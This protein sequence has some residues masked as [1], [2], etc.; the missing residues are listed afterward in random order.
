MIGDDEKEQEKDETGIREETREE[1]EE[2]EK[3]TIQKRKEVVTTSETAEENEQII[4]KQEPP[5]F[6]ETF[7]NQQVEQG[8]SCCLNVR[9]NDVKIDDV[10]WMCGDDVITSSR[11][12]HMTVVSDNDLHSLIINDIRLLDTSQYTCIVT[13]SSGECQ[14][15]ADILV[16]RKFNN[17]LSPNLHSCST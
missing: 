14:C 12:N 4:I 8:S 17:I 5:Q 10:K 13:N 7:E 3:A 2:E 15:S 6:I 9:V 1:K 16:L 11:F